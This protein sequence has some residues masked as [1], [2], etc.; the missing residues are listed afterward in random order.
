MEKA[1]CSG[2]STKHS[3]ALISSSLAEVSKVT[4]RLVS[5]CCGF[6]TSPRLP[7]SSSISG[8]SFGFRPLRLM[9]IPPSIAAGAAA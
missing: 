9:R 3:T 4:S 7:N 8:I 1:I 5:V 2:S 6:S